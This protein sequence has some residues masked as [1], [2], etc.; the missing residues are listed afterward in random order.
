MG[1]SHSKNQDSKEGA[2]KVEEVHGEWD[3]VIFYKDNECWGNVD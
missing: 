1:T 3:K 2:F